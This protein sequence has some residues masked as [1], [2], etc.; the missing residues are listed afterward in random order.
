MSRHIFITGGAGFIGSHTAERLLARGDRV[1]VL[2]VFGYGYDPALKEQNAALLSTKSGF[3]LVRGDIRDA[4]LLDKLF[5]E[6]KPDVVVHLAARAGVR[7]SLLEPDSYSDVNITGTIRILDAMKTHKI[8]HMVFASS[9]SIYGARTKG[10]FKESDNVDVP[11]SPYAASKKAGELFCANYHYLYKINATCLRFFTVYGPRQRPEMA[12]RLFAER[13]R[14]EERITMFGDGS[15]IRDYTYVDDIVTGIVAAVD[16]PLGFQIINLGNSNP[17]RLD[18]LI[19]EIGKAVGKEPLIDVLPDQPGDV[20]MTFADVG[21]AR[22]LLN[23]APNTP[24]GKG[25]KAVVD[26]LFGEE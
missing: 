12:I 19:S 21:K 9:S 11:A 16:K 24:I 23:Y 10:P 17:I 25:L 4:D 3:R 8:D 26:W 20:P 15:S 6:D 7:P 2:D 22:E 5:S 13:I 1:T 14:N 18:D